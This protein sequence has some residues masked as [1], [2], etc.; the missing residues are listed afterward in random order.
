[1]S[2]NIRP[3]I[4]KKNKYWI[5]KH[6]YYELKHFCMQYSYWEE[7]LRALDGFSEESNGIIIDKKDKL[8]LS[9]SRVERV[10]MRRQF[11]RDCMDEVEKAARDTDPIIGRYILI[12]VTKGMPYDVLRMNY[13]IPCARKTY[14]D[15][16][17]KFFWLL[18]QTR[19]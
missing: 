8:P 17:R 11:Y 15:L 5:E 1:M 14:Y 3:E 12:A 6:R 16:Y 2:E 10:V 7:R 9:Q 13:D 19:K 4:S 18:S